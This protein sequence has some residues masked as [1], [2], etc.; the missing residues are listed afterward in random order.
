VLNFEHFSKPKTIENVTAWMFDSLDQ[1][2]IKS[3]DINQLSADG[4]SNAIG[5]VAEYESLSRTDR[6]NDVSITRC[7]AHQNERSAGYASGTLKFAQPKNEALGAIL[8]KSHKIQVDIS[9]AP[10]RMS[11]FLSI[12]KK[13]ERKPLL[14]PNPSVETRWNSSIDETTR[15][16]LIMG[17][18]CETM[19]VL[20]DRGG[21][22]Y[23]QL[24]TAE[25]SL[26]DKSRLTYTNRDK[27]ILRQYEFAAS[28]AK[29]FSLFT[30]DKKDTWSYILFAARI[31]V[32]TS[33]EES[34]AILP[35]ML[36][37]ISC[38]HFKL[39]LS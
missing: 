36:I 26:G 24:T 19:C 21:Y 8:K 7:L 20:L 29:T 6:S 25:K 22:D 37:Q 30:Q 39:L 23:D 9:R 34:F 12:Q 10:T 38:A 16:N 28:P 4:A 35:G 27:M 3:G 5:S 13:R 33:R 2:G 31:A 11:V 1:V 32:N 18:M 17:D 15:A 14:K